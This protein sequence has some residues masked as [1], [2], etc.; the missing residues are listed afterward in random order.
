[1]EVILLEK[2]NNLGDLGEKVNVKSG[3][4]RNFLIPSGRA[5]PATDANVEEFEK[6]R[7]ELEKSAAEK[8]TAAEA[9]KAELDGATV[10][11]TQKAGEEG[12]LFGSVGTTDIAEAL[13]AAG[14]PVDKAEVRL[15]EGVFRV[16]GGYEV[17][18]HLHTDVDAIVNV[19]VEGEE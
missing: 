18:I 2:V 1:M 4:G 11:I 7:A 14:K 9:R 8:L 6:R 17:T 15:P 19:L 13:T 10:T 12:K 16:T 5:L 3:Y